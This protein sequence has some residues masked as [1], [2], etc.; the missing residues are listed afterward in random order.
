M[1][2]DEILDMMDHA[3]GD[4]NVSDNAMRWKP[5]L[6]V[7]EQ[8]KLSELLLPA[9]QWVEAFPGHW[10][11]VISAGTLEEEETVTPAP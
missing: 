6:Q 11:R 4:V 8:F 9:G 10:V 5:D 7:K 2:T 1:N 3:H